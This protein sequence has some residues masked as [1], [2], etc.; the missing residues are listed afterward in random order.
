M[1]GQQNIKKIVMCYFEMCQWSG[2]LLAGQLA[3]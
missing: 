3:L 1:H 2:Q